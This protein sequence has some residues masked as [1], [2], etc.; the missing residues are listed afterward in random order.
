MAVEELVGIISAVCT[1][2]GQISGAHVY[3]FASPPISHVAAHYPFDDN[4]ADTVVLDIS[5]NANHGTL[6]GGDNTEDK[7]TTGKVN[8]AFDFNG[9]DDYVN[10]NSVAAEG[11]FGNAFS[12]ACWGKLDAW[13]QA[14]GIIGMQKRKI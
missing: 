10:V 3:L 2:T 6:G 1:T 9:S 12:V 4:E 7:N 8:D 11:F 14:Q 13:N 5:K